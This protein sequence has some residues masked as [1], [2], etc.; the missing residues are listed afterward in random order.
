M[1]SPRRDRND[2]KL[3]AYEARIRTKWGL[4]AYDAVQETGGQLFDAQSRGT[5]FVGLLAQLADLESDRV[6]A[7][8]AI[9]KEHQ[10]RVESQGSNKKAHSTHAITLNDIRSTVAV[11]KARNGTTSPLR[12]SQ[13]SHDSKPSQSRSNS[14]VN[15]ESAA[16]DNNLVQGVQG[17]AN[18][19]KSHV[20]DSLNALT[21][22][23]PH[24]GGLPLLTPTS[25][26]PE[27]HAMGLR[28][29]EDKHTTS[30]SF[31]NLDES[32]TPS[33]ASVNADNIPQ[34][35]REYLEDKEDVLL[36][37]QTFENS[38][39]RIRIRNAG[40]SEP[41]RSVVGRALSKFE[42]RYEEAEDAFMHPE[43]RP[44]N[45]DNGND[46]DRDSCFLGEL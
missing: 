37:R 15:A 40:R 2:K 32:S 20:S 10:R 26:R 5:C 3:E 8:E 1:A 21:G 46:S 9:L 18:L 33:T 4:S 35:V 7:Q 30:A 23:I 44:P 24:S 42:Q 45:W 36:V 31:V 39:R 13:T 43:T 12:A 16:P 34:S 41:L 14:T 22:K 27:H 28:C 11:L 17:M 19:K 38:I 29:L 6:K 25:V